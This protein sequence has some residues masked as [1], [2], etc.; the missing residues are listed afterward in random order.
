MRPFQYERVATPAAAV[1]MAAMMRPG[2][3]EPSVTTPVQFLAGGTNLVDMMKIGV[4]Q[5]ERLVDINAIADTRLGGIEVSD[6]GLWLGALARMAQVAAHPEIVRR[7]PVI[8][9][10]LT[11]AASQQLR[12]MASIG[13]NVLQRTRCP[14]YRDPSYAECNKRAP[15]SGCAA[16]LGFNRMHAVLGTSE[17]CI[18]AYPGDF[19]QA[20]IALDARVDITGPRGNRTLA[21]A[22]LHR[23]PGDRPETDTRLAPGELITAFAINPLPWARRSK[24]LK[25]RDRESYEFALASA[26]VALDMAGDEVRQARIA[27]GGV[28]TVPWRASAAEQALEGKRLDAA[29]LAAAADA[30]FADARPLEHNGFKIALGKETLMRALRETAAME[31]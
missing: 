11:L 16:R 23:R 9:Q 6:D 27:L 15:G 24:Y 8:T 30:A 14:Y 21:F 13:G 19:A 7:Y 2:G 12:N 17:A 31:I 5:P 10:S 29:T 1:K 18:A 3:D 4:M 25:V 20:L 28:A 26:A 22:D